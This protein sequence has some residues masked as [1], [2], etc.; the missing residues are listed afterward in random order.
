[1]THKGPEEAFRLSVA[2]LKTLRRFGFTSCPKEVP[3]GW[4]LRFEKKGDIYKDFEPGFIKYI[5]EKGKRTIIY[6]I[7]CAWGD[8]D[9]SIQINVS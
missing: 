4:K 3:P 9:C 1:M 7:G 6:T 8:W 2:D 5:Y